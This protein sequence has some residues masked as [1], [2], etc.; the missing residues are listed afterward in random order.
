MNEYTDLEQLSLVGLIKEMADTKTRLDAATKEKAN[1]QKKY[2]AL[3]IGMIPERM[4]EEELTTLTVEGIGR[5]S[6]TPDIFSSV[7]GET[8]DE[9]WDWLRDN[10][11]GE[12]IKETINAGT[13]KAVLKAMM[14]KGEDFPT[15]LFKVIPYSRASITRISK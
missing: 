8:K 4:D 3:R 6:L 13:L 7:P 2:D 14:K 5:V 10:G 1:L 12:I 11:H 9:A 15:E